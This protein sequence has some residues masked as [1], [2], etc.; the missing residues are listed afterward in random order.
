MTRP[1]TPSA[2]LALTAFAFLTLSCAG[3]H[4]GPV[5]STL[6]STPTQKAATLTPVPTST[7]PSS[8]SI[9]AQEDVRSCGGV[10]LVAAYMKDV[11]MNAGRHGVYVAFGNRSRTPCVFPGS[12][13]VQLLNDRGEVTISV[14]SRFS[15]SVPAGP[16]LLLPGLGDLM[17]SLSPG[18]AWLRID[19]SPHDDWARGSCSQPWEEAVA[20]R[21]LPPS[22][23]G[24]LYVDLPI[25][26]APC[27]GHVRVSPFA[28]VPE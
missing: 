14:P 26:I 1:Y 28:P 6:T 8:T 21:I 15:A 25:P 5:S 12:P 9:T 20:F 16:V 7:V 27:R 2:L 18:Q 22:G 10:D 24:E 17:P 4:G 11:G 23:S 13:G 3:D 19:W